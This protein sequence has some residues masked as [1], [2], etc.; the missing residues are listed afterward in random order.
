MTKKRH[1]FFASRVMARLQSSTDSTCTVHGVKIVLLR[2]MPPFP[3]L[4]L[5]LSALGAAAV[6]GRVLAPGLAELGAGGSEGRCCGD[7]E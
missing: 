5:F 1:E 3:E 6:L 4:L 7:I 2:S